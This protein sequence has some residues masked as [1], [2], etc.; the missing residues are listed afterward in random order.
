MKYLLDTNACIHILNNS[1]TRLITRLAGHNP[2]EIVL[3]S[4]VKAE[5][6][7]GAYKSERT[8]EN[9]RLLQRF[10]APFT[11]IAFDDQCNE[12]Y[13]LI[14]R[15]LERQGRPIGPTDLIIAATAVANELTLITANTQEFGRVI[16]LALENWE[17]A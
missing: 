13:G 2:S 8:A 7:F 11:S 9:L 1:S 12:P 16:G 15:E 6:I 4:M 3:C 10:F 17:A 14:R 5:L